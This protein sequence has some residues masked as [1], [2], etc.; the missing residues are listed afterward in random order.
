MSDYIQVPAQDFVPLNNLPALRAILHTFKVPLKEGCTI[1]G[2]FIRILCRGDSIV[3][4]LTKPAL[5]DN[6]G[7]IDI[8][9]PKPQ[10]MKTI[11][12]KMAIPCQR[13]HAGF[14]WNVHR[15]SPLEAGPYI[16][17]SQNIQFIDYPDFCSPD[18]IEVVD[19]FDFTNVAIGLSLVDGQPTITVHRRWRELETEMLLDVRNSRSPFLGHRINK[20]LKRRGYQGVTPESSHHITNWL[21]KCAAGEK[22]YIGEKQALHPEVI[23]NGVISL[24]ERG[25]APKQDIIMFLGKWEVV[26][27]D[28]MKGDYSGFNSCETVDW[29]LSKLHGQNFENR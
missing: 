20:Y 15:K 21:V 4:Y 13:S 18:P 8:F 23:K 22:F 5:G 14:G 1:A 27:Y 2:G 10:V 25:V 24:F 6:H 29:A 19:R 3:D 16:G 11:T 9:L 28:R 12:T 7:D 17:A 26:V